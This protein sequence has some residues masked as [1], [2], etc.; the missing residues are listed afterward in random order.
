MLNVMQYAGSEGSYLKA[1]DLPQGAN[2]E[3]IIEGFETVDFEKDGNKITKLVLKFANKDKKLPL[4]KTN[5]M[6]IAGMY[7][8]DGEA[9]VGKKIY[10]YR[11][12]TD[13]GGNTVDCVRVDVPRQV[14]AAEPSQQQAPEQTQ[15]QSAPANFDNFDDDIPFS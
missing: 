8:E 14:V 13:F 6:T 1:A 3:V 12:T 9:W 4:N 15:Q 7:G 10:I 5:L 2:V 11:T